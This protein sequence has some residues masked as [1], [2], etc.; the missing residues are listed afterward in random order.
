MDELPDESDPLDPNQANIIKKK[1]GFVGKVA[2]MQ[3]TLREQSEIVIKIKAIN[4]NKLPQGI[5]LGGKEAF[6]MFLE[7]KQ[8][9]L[10]NE[11]RPY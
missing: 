9:D 4:N 5:I 1:I 3:K 11:A 10:E 2:K 6:L 7:I 8:K